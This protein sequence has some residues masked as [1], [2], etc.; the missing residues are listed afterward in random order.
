[1]PMYVQ[2]LQYNNPNDV[3]ALYRTNRFLPGEPLA[4]AEMAWVNFTA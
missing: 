1:M 2:R 3:D 4:C